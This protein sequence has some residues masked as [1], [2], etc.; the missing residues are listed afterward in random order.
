LVNDISGSTGR[1]RD[2]LH[3]MLVY[4]IVLCVLFFTCAPFVRV[5][6][7]SV[8]HVKLFSIIIL[9]S[10]SLVFLGHAQVTVRLCKYERMSS[11]A[12]AAG[13]TI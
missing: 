4:L 9:S 8:V 13:G 11:C 5:Y 1:A 10:T 12:E 7:L 2:L 6:F 3:V